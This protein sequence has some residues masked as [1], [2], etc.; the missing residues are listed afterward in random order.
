MTATEKPDLT[1]DAPADVKPLFLSITQ[2]AVLLGC[3]RTTVYE[4]CARRALGHIRVGNL[5]KITRAH[6]DEFLK[7]NSVTP[8]PAA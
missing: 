8:R 7:A 4:L 6:V 5:I 2:V 3:G 1:A